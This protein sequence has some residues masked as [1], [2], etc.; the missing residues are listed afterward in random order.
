MPIDPFVVLTGL[1]GQRWFDSELV[2]A[3]RGK[4]PVA[5]TLAPHCLHKQNRDL[6]RRCRALASGGDAVP[7][8]AMP[9][10][11]PHKSAERNQL[12]A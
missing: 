9:M 10:V 8:H 1:R 3:L 12:A 4:V 6:G 5:L 7:E 2:M 11:T